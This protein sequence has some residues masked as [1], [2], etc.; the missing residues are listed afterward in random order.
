MEGD[1]YRG[2]TEE[3]FLCSY[4]S[5][6]QRG[7]EVVCGV[8]DQA[9]VEIPRTLLQ[10]SYCKLYS[11]W[12][13]GASWGTETTLFLFRAFNPVAVL[14][15]LRHLASSYLTV[16]ICEILVVLILAAFVAAWR[17]VPWVIFH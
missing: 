13:L 10:L 6:L 2:Q 8:C 15:A 17:S 16:V 9:G 12:A 11:M 7:K 3:I 14:E 1:K 5:C 4:L